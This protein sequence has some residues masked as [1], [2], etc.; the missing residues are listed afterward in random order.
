MSDQAGQIA[1][2]SA[3]REGRVVAVLRASSLEHLPGVTSALVGSGLRCIE[4]TTTT[5]GHLDVLAGLV[6]SVRADVSIGL[7]TVTDV[8]TGVRALEAGAA[9]I[10]TPGLV[11]GLPQVAHEHGVPCIVG[12]WSPTEVMAAARSGAD[13]I[14]VFPASSGGVAHLRSLRDPFPHLTFVPSGGVTLADARDYIAAGADAVGIGGA[15]TGAALRS[16]S[17]EDLLDLGE[18]AATLLESVASAGRT[19]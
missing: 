15:L 9:F 13:A 17:A 8:A 14:K 19:R 18:R 4:L 5:P 12:T 6:A 16:G 11:E 10:V 1:L 3:L 2:P 7:G